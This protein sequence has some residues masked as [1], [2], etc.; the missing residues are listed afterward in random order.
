MNDNAFSH[1]DAHSGLNKGYSYFDPNA[2]MPGKRILRER[3]ELQIGDVILNRYEL[4]K[5]LGSGAMGVVFKCRDQVSQVEYALKMVPPEL[6]RDAEAMEDVRDNFQLIH[7]L[8]H[9]NIASADFLERDE[10][11]SYFLVMEYARGESLTQWMKRKWRTG[12]PELSEVAGIVKQIASALDYAHS[13]RI[14][15]RDIKP[16]NVMVDDAGKVKVLD[17]GLASK[18]RS[19]MTMLSVNQSSTSGTPHYLSPEQF[20]GR[21][22]TPASDQYALGV[23]TY[24]MLSGHLPFEADDSNIL[25]SAVLSDEAD[26]VDDVSDAVNQCLRKVLSKDK[27]MR[28]GTCTA[29]ADALTE[30]FALPEVLP[31]SPTY[32]SA[33]VSTP[34]PA[35]SVVYTPLGKENP[36]LRRAKQFLENE[37]YE[38]ALNYCEQTLNQEPE[39]GW[40]YYYR[41]MGEKRVNSFKE[42]TE[43]D[44]S[45]DKTYALAKRFADAELKSELDKIEEGYRQIEEARRRAEEQRRKEKEAKASRE[46]L[47]KASVYRVNLLVQYL[48]TEKSLNPRP[49]IIKALRSAILREQ[50]LQ[51][52]KGVLTADMACEVQQYSEKV[53]ENSGDLENKKRRIEKKEKKTFIIAMNMV[54]VPFILIVVLSEKIG[55]LSFGLSI[56]WLIFCGI[57]WFIWAEITNDLRERTLGDD[58]CCEI[59][60]NTVIGCCDP[61]AK[62]CVIPDGVV[63]IEEEAFAECE[64]ITSIEFPSSLRYIRFNLFPSYGNGKLKEVRVPHGCKIDSPNLPLGL[65]IIRY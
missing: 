37:D 58:V 13:Q 11:G 60:D 62:H 44:L 26:P 17:F 56:G 54:F 51:R 4:L 33:D 35:E 43:L 25:R 3:G 5:K 46:K 32:L 47:R 15:H 39:N 41:L 14:L 34:H 61:N 45:H 20:K 65:K 40:A 64:K 53:M 36:L 29:F 31:S 22:P 30:A 2:T 19:T 48:D 10:Y 23:L 16:A 49:D 63:A 57:F 6:A 27:T 55:V 7:S 21:Y 59:V 42:M 1:A 24:Q 12:R 8:K 18:V 28:Y 52:E 38:S 50:H 9:P